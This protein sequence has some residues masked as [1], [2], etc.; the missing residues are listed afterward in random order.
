MIFPGPAEYLLT[1]LVAF[2]VAA[3]ATPMFR[4]IA[5][6]YNILDHPTQHRKIHPRPTPYLGGLAFFAAYLVVLVESIWRRPELI[7]PVHYPLA[8]L[9]AVII[10]LGLADDIFNLSGA[11]KLL[12]ELMVGALLYYWAVGEQGLAKPLHAIIDLGPLAPLIAAVW[13]AG[14]M[15]AINFTDGLDGLAAG[16]VA[17]ASAMLL[18]VGIINE[19]P[20]TCLV[21][22][23]LLGSTLGFLLYNFHPASIFMGDAGALFLG[24]MLGGATLVE[25]QKGAAVVALIVPVIT[26]ALP[27]AD[28][29]LSFLRRLR[30]AREGRFFHP[31]REHLHHRLLA[32]GL[33]QRRA[34]MIMYAFSLLM[35]LLAIL[36]GILPSPFK[37]GVPFVAALFTAAAV[38]WLHRIEQ[39]RRAER[40]EPGPRD[41]A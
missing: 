6:R 24:F 31:D 23:T 36:A 33:D 35:G 22:A 21:M 26:I 28:T 30:R 18:V 37:P 3:L 9:G 16:L 10:L 17:I 11:P 38:V 40:Q 7:A 27:I 25:Q 15:N 41:Q 32:L 8:V 5:R 13:V 4:W 2:L 19:Q 12:V 1:T 20:A 14:V 39:R 34:V 29:L